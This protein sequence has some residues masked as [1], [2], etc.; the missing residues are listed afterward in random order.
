MA[1]AFLITA[2]FPHVNEKLLLTAQY[3]IVTLPY[4]SALRV[5][6]LPYFQPNVKGSTS[7]TCY[8]LFSAQEPLFQQQASPNLQY[9]GTYE[10]RFRTGLL[11]PSAPPVERKASSIWQIAEPASALSLST[12]G[13]RLEGKH[14]PQCQVKP[15]RNSVGDPDMID[16]HAP[17]DQ[18]DQPFC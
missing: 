14:I 10:P 3:S 11:M 4:L 18:R 1:I 2:Q 7:R 17:T 8:P 15:L 6:S 12:K 16:S 5:S 13:L 9:C